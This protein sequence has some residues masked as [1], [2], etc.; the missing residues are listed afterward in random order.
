MNREMVAEWHENG[1]PSYGSVITLGNLRTAIT[2]SGGDTV[3]K[4]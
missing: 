3:R 2:H 1:A 4:R